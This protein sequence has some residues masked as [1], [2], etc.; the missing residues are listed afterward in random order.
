M[1]HC[2][3]GVLR[4]YLDEPSAVG[5][6]DRAHLTSCSRCAAELEY[7]RRDRDAVADLFGGAVPA[8]PGPEELDVAWSALQDR[9]ADPATVPA[10]AALTAL[11]GGAT[12][13][14]RGR[15][16]DRVL[17][18]PVAVAAT[19][20]VVLLGGTA[21][22]AAAD[23][24]PI[25]RPDKVTPVAISSQ[26]VRALDQLGRLAELSAYGEVDAPKN[27][28]PVEVKDAAAAKA[29]TGLAAP[30]VGKLPRGVSG[31][32]RYYVVDQ[33]TVRVT[34]SAAKLK[35][36]ATSAGVTLPPMPG[37]LDGTRL[38]VRGGPGLAEVWQHGSGTPTL[39]V[40]RANAP[41]ATTEGASL[42][43]VRDYL[44]A[45]PGLSPALRDQLRTLGDGTTLPIP[46]PQDMATS[47]RAD[48][49]GV[50][51]TVVESKDRTM[52]GVVWVRDG[53]MDVVLGPLSREDVLAVARGVG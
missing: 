1:N 7:A 50:S 9:L 26:D 13:R 36:A 5:D 4:R 52:A 42:T 30:G 14:R 41:T 28:E 45:M 38:Q 48:I 18:R 37:G 47:S 11:P 10:A 20:G 43:V 32:P 25:F 24:I 27:V 8:G 29:R 39:V 19:A 2:A 3:D 6:A 53:V 12:G 49:G 34:F 44:L 31:D 21:A 16:A 15:W 35:Q 33:Q 17:R 51:A 22:A 46:V 40:A 23:L